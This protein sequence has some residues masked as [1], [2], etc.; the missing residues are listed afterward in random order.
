MKPLY[1]EEDR[2][3]I[4]MN[5]V[6]LRGQGRIPIVD[7]TPLLRYISEITP[8][9]EIKKT[10]LEEISVEGIRMP[11]FPNMRVSNQSAKVMPCHCREDAEEYFNWL[12][13]IITIDEKTTDETRK[14]AVNQLFLFIFALRDKIH[15]N[16]ND[17][18]KTRFDWERKVIILKNA[19]KEVKGKVDGIDSDNEDLKGDLEKETEKIS[20]V[21]ERIVNWQK[22]YQPYLDGLEKERKGIDNALKG[23]ENGKKGKR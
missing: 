13:W 8:L 20:E 23:E 19:L 6:T 2:Y 12:I 17:F 22:H 7:F 5:F 4:V 18:L 3:K 11:T 14:E 10:G 1:S 16:L 15:V 21:L 9:R